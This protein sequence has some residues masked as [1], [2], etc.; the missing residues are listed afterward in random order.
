MGLQDAIRAAFGQHRTIHS[1]QAVTVA[2][3]DG[4]ET[5]TG[6]RG[7]QNSTADAGI[8]GESGLDT[9]FVRVDPSEFTEPEKGATIVVGGEDAVVTLSRLD[10]VQGLMI[11]EYQETRPVA[12]V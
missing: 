9:S 5:C 12:G 1:D 11:I 8:F 10:S 4:T 2:N 3:E 7:L 6:L